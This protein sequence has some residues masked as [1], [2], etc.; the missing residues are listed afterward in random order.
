MIQLLKKYL[1][2]KKGTVSP[3]ALPW[4]SFYLSGFKVSEGQ[5]QLGLKNLKAV[6]EDVPVTILEHHTLRDESWRQKTE[7]VYAKAAEVGHKVMTAAEFIGCENI[8]LESKRKILYVENPPSKEFEKWMR[9]S[10]TK[11]S[12]IKPPI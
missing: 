6:V 9:N 4:R 12:S 5:L 7:Q 2:I 1:K 10:L 11:K 3:I 8:F